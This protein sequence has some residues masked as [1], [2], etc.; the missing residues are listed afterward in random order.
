MAAVPVNGSRWCSQIPRVSSGVLY[1]HSAPRT[2][3]SVAFETV[4]DGALPRLVAVA[5]RAGMAAPMPYTAG[6]GGETAQDAPP[7][8]AFAPNAICGRDFRRFSFASDDVH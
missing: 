3:A 2:R 4:P 6:E 7:T 5:A 1:R 8:E